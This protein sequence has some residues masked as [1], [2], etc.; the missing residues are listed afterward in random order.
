MLAVNPRASEAG[1]FPNLAALPEQVDAALVMVSPRAAA[2]AVREAL[3]AGVRRI[4]LH[5]GSVSP[6]ALQACRDAGTSLVSGRCI[7][8]FLEPVRSVHR[9]H[10]G[11]L[12]L[13]GRLPR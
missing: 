2:G 12:R 11:V 1:F 8:M 7:L 6:D 4:W 9:F 13:F 3:L 5:Q 10:R